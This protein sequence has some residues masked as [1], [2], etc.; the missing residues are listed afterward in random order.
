[1]QPINFDRALEKILYR[2]PRFEPEAFEFLKEALDF[3]VSDE[4]SLRIHN[5]RHVSAKELLLGFKEFALKE[6]GCMAS[7]LLSEWGINSC[8][9]V[10]DMVFLLIDE[11]VFGRQD[12]DKREDFIEVY[13]FTE[14]FVVPYLPKSLA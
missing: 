12:S 1:M 7:T 6:Y 13:D 5:Q 4:F 9:D 10:G 14:A 8:S 2:E 11:Q 3:T